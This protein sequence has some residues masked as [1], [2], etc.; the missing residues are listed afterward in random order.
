MRQQARAGFTVIE[1]MIVVVII[2]VLAVVGVPKMARTMEA[3]TAKSA[4]SVVAADV[5]A[6]FATAARARR[7]VALHCDCSDRIYQVTDFDDEDTRPVRLRRVLNGGSGM[8]VSSI[9]FVPDDI[10]IQPNGLANSGLVVT[11]SVG[12]STKRVVVSRTG[13]VRIQG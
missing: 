4:A 10:T 9:R 3:S 5:E 8:A 7:P 1:V 13:L 12:S 11:I 2:G 6:A